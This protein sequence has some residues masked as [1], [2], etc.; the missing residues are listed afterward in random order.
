MQLILNDLMTLG[1][2]AECR[3]IAGKSGVNR[4]IKSITVLE[5][6]E[7]AKW[8][9]GGEFIL[10]SMYAVKE[11]V[12][13]QLKL[14]DRL[15][16]SGAAGLGIKPAHFL[17]QVSRD[18]IEKAN[19]LEFP[20][21]E[22]PEHVTYLDLMSP[23]MHTLFDNKVVLQED[24]DRAT[25]ILHEMALNQQGI[26]EYA[27]TIRLLVANEITIE[28]ELPTIN[29]FF[30]NNQIEPL[31]SSQ[32][33]ELS[34]LGRALQVDRIINGETTACL[35]V[36]IV[37][38][39]EYFGN[40]SSWGNYDEHRSKD[41]AVLEKAASL[42][43]FEFLKNKMQLDIEHRYESDFMRELLFSERV[44]EKS[45]IEWGGKYHI[46][47]DDS[48]ICILFSVK[49]GDSGD[50]DF[51]VLRNYRL[52]NVLKQMHSDALV[53]SI[54][55][56]ICILLPIKNGID[57]K[58]TVMKYYH[59]IK[60]L[61]GQEFQLSTGVGKVEKGIRGIQ[62]G[63]QQSEKALYFAE[64]QHSNISLYFYEDLGVY[65]LIYS[66]RNEIEL[67]YFYNETLQGILRDS[68]GAELLKTLEVYF[69]NNESLKDTASALFI[70]VNTLKY[71]L[72]RVEELSGYSVRNSEDKMNLFLALKI[73]HL[74]G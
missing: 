64:Q 67:D 57:Y 11:D 9:S 35:V 16:L 18:I 45:L 25:R 34:I 73:S 2:F 12:E 7:V 37:S 69:A 6:P 22:I 39:G 5:V 20:I 30:A 23:V 59:Q 28:S 65:R 19:A 13:A 74:V 50:K 31:T 71:R 62:L 46:T 42:L 1:G 29:S 66:V 10:T 27:N 51:Q 48:Y 21:I 70:H 15:N 52:T 24:L 72:N 58:A 63:F 14:I 40:I 56:G 33:Q 4:E 68:K 43:S 26:E 53:G 44:V 8:V 3:L 60:G 54:R 17:G 61:I 47:K 38:D 32:K 36:P 49:K 41:I 55:N